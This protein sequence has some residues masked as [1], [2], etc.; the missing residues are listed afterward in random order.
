[1]HLL[2]PT[3]L[4]LFLPLF[5][6][7]LCFMGGEVVVGFSCCYYY[8]CFLIKIDGFIWFTFFD[9]FSKI[10]NANLLNMAIEDMFGRFESTGLQWLAMFRLRVL[11]SICYLCYILLHSFR[12]ESNS[13]FHQFILH[14]PILT[15]IL[16]FYCNPAY[17]LASQ[18]DFKVPFCIVLKV[19]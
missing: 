15:L 8:Y 1:M 9:W 14:D 17:L 16:T 18:I 12:F 11:S 2:A 13:L 10:Y 3:S 4:V 19:I 7:F 6:L 5:Y